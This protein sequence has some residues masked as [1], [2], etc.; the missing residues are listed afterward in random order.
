[1]Q[2]LEAS[3][4]SRMNFECQYQSLS[5]NFMH[6]QTCF[7]LLLVF[8]TCGG[9]GYLKGDWPMLDLI[10]CLTPFGMNT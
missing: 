1:M 3:Y 4:T 7:I 9:S 5:Y 8:H 2:G 10:T 6:I